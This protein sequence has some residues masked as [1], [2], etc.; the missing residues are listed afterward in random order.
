MPRMRSASLPVRTICAALLALLLAVR[1]LSPAGFMPAFSH[2][3]VTIVPCPDQD[4]AP[5]PAP[6]AHHDHG[7]KA[8]HQP[9][10]YAAAGNPPAAQMQPAHIAALLPV[11][12]APLIGR[13]FEPAEFQRVHERPPLRGPPLPA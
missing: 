9:C 1:L 2:G 6:M 8:L 5:A 11:A 3:T 7:P 10:P 12:S 4:P 13:T